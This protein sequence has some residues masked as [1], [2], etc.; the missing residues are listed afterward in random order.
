MLLRVGTTA[1]VVALIDA[2]VADLEVISLADPLAAL[3][4]VS[5]DVTLR[6]QL[7]LTSGGRTTALEIQRHHLR[8]ARLH[9]DRLPEWT[10]R[11][12]LLW[13]DTLDRLEQGIEHVAD[14]LDW[15]IKL[16]MFEHRAR[17]TGRPSPVPAAAAVDTSAGDEAWRAEL[18]E[19]DVRFGHVDESSL[20][21]ALDE[22][23][24]LR[25]RMVSKAQIE[26]A[27]EH[28]PRSGRA[29]IR[30]RV[31]AR[32]ARQDDFSTCAWN[33]IYD[34]STGA[35]LDLSD[36]FASCEA[37]CHDPESTE[38]L[39][40]RLASLLKTPAT[41]AAR[42]SIRWLAD[43]LAAPRDS[44][45]PGR[46]V[47]HAVR[48]NA[49]AFDLRNEGRL[50]EAEW[51]MRSALQ[52]DVA[53]RHDGHPKVRHRRNNL[54]TVLL[55]Q[56][57]LREASALVT[58]AWPAADG[59][60]DIT[61]ARVLATRLLIAILSGESRDLYLGQLKTHLGT[62][63]LP[64]FA[65]VDRRWQMAAVLRTLTTIELEDMDF[66]LA[67]VEVL[68]GARTP[69]ALDSFRCW[70]DTVP[71]GLDTPWP[72]CASDL[73]ATSPVTLARDESGQHALVSNHCES[74]IDSGNAAVPSS[75]VS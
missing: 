28:P 27:C 46:S 45:P 43:K 15:A 69:D 34:A 49:V 36:P 5:T 40:A 75:V 50:D 41:P 66:L 19:L 26:R 44:A 39:L 20:F 68:N 47:E 1:L 8:L 10:E 16:A 52:I 22:A 29:R 54:G 55:L 11:M 2:G 67:I 6:Q 31:V 25:H 38:T 57:R 13:E 32:L 58:L 23:G 74:E 62:W 71:L 53:E 33:N 51:L 59:P 65:D 7:D 18:C 4:T 61:T 70:R 3:T 64:D 37:W 72:S 14:R 35:R 56:G 60:Y 24:V 63:P 30:G 12:C 73:T 17:R 42:R 9:R 48:L 21:R